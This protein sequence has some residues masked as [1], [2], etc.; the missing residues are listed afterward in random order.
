MYVCYIP[1]GKVN[2][3]ALGQIDYEKA[4][5]EELEEMGLRKKNDEDVEDQVPL[6]EGSYDTPDLEHGVERR[7][8]EGDG[9]GDRK[10][11]PEVRVQ[12]VSNA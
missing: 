12:E 9:E 10:K 5:A 1:W 7:Q 8:E 11:V 4:K 2:G 3:Q 6:K